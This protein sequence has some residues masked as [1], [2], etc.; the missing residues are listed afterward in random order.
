MRRE[1]TLMPK[2]EDL[3]DNGW[4]EWG[5]HVLLELQR[6]NTCMYQQN[7]HITG[8]REAMATLKVQ[9][10]IWGAVAGAIPA[11]VALIILF[12]QGR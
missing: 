3:Q 9:A 4:G 1:S 11:T 12:L 7:E 2:E 6:L 5:K 8:M 10:G